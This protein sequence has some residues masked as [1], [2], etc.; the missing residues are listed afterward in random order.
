MQNKRNLSNPIYYSG[1]HDDGL[2]YHHPDLARPGSQV[3][4]AQV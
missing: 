4:A 2:R 1:H 3:S